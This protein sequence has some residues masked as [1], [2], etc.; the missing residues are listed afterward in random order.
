MKRR[1]FTRVLTAGLVAGSVHPFSSAAD[2]TD[3]PNILFIFSDDH[4]NRTI[5]CYDDALHRTPNID[6]IANEGALFN[7]SFVSNSICGPSRA[8]IMTG[9]HSHACGMFANHSRW[10]GAQ[11]LFPRALRQSDY[12]TALIGKWHLNRDPGDE[13]DDW[14]ILTGFG[15]Q[16]SYY[17]PE[18]KNSKGKEARDIGYSTD[19]I[20][21][22]SLA[23]L[24]ARDATKPFLLMTQFKAPHT[25]RMPPVRNARLYEDRTF[26]LPETYFDDYA[27]RQPYADQAWT[28]LRGRGERMSGLFPRFED[29]KPGDSRTM[30]E[31]TPEQRRAYHE[32]RDPANDALR[33][34]IAV[35]MSDEELDREGYQRFMRDYLRCVT[36][37]D[38][39]VGRLLDY[40]DEAG[41]TRDTIV[42]YSADQSYFT[43]EHGWAEKRFMYEPAFQTPFVL[44]Y[45]RRVK[46]GQR[47]DALIQNIDYAPTFLDYTGLAAPSDLHG[48]SLRPLLEGKTPGDWRK[49]LYYHYYDDIGHNVERHDGVRTEQFKLMHFYTDDVYELYDL[50]RDPNEVRNVADDPE[51]AARFRT[52]QTELVRLRRHYNVP[53]DV[54]T[55]P[56]PIQRREQTGK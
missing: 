48:R 21:D 50:V 14:K 15:K 2:A 24:K 35:G 33:A 19:L 27:T 9:K 26:P 22:D 18:F 40:L 54:F 32:A 7:R 49:S 37:I 38:E 55:S 12:Q 42:V 46:A 16:G 25:P 23:W 31:M 8:C 28:K 13:F 20:T 29:M 10:N 39:N 45:P 36:T 11:W 47:V 43:G 51:Y 17:N 4:A 1:D 34:R 56:Y 41:L 30:D 53:D 6:R 44:R 52:M 3:R 5:S